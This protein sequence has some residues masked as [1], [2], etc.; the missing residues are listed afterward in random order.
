MPSV[1]RG[2]ITETIKEN[3]DYVAGRGMDRR[4]LY[5]KKEGLLNETVWIHQDPP[6][7][8]KE[9]EQRRRLFIEK[10]TALKKSPNLSVSEL[11]FQLRN[12]PKKEFHEA[13]LR[14][15]M[16]AVVDAYK[17]QPNFTKKMPKIK[18]L[19]R[20]VKVLKDV[21]KT[22][23]DPETQKVTN[24]SSG[25]AFAEFT[26]PDLSL[27]AVRYLNNMQLAGNRPLIVDFAL[28][29]ARKVQKRAQKLEKHQR[30][31]ME[32]KD[33]D[34]KANRAE[35]RQ[36]L[37]PEETGTKEHSGIEVSEGVSKR[38]ETVSIGECEDITVL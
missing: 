6:L 14:E 26:D 28:D 20:Q 10:D 36:K 2:N 32:K 30:L 33:A 35:K 17:E 25:L 29:D 5:L 21:D 15:L 8:T 7:S 4:N 22:F 24:M 19:I 11:R 3:K 18:T 13:E 23:V 38:R 34:K 12:L 1:A 9:L 16:V 31:A 27:F 37:Q